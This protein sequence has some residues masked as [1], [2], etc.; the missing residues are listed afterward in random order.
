MVD[1]RKTL[2]LIYIWDQRLLSEM[3]NIVISDTPRA[4]LEDA[5]ILSSGFVEGNCALHHGTTSCVSFAMAKFL[6]VMLSITISTTRHAIVLMIS[7]E[8]K[9]E[10]SSTPW[11]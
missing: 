10:D 7:Y 11:I 6:M 8:H 2:S 5:L 4:G 3:L 9:E 1:R